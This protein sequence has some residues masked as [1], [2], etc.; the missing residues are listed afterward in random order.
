VDH[1]RAV[2]H[3]SMVDHRRRRPNGLPERG[4]GAPPVSGSS[5]VMGE[6]E[7]EAWGV[8]TVGEGGRCGA[9]GR[10]TTMDRNGSGLELGVRAIRVRMERANARTGMWCGDGALGRLF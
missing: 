3:G 7:E 8:P 2:V 9:R 4:L 10:P 5:P 6:N 1:D